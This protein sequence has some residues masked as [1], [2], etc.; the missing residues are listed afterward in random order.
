MEHK[1]LEHE[2]YLLFYTFYANI[3]IPVKLAGA[4][5]HSVVERYRRRERDQL[6]AR[7]RGIR[8][9]ILSAHPRGLQQG[10]REGILGRL[11]GEYVADD[12]DLPIHREPAPSQPG[13]AVLGFH[14]WRCDL[15]APCGCDD[16]YPGTAQ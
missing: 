6:Q 13:P 10:A 5:P 2:I 15:P 9:G 1:Q 14:V 12:P 16:C 7:G 4:H 11:D 8:L 3:A